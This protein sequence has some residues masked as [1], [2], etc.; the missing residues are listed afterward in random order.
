MIMMHDF[1]KIESPFVRKE[2]NGKYVVT[3]EIAKNYEWVFND[4][5]VHAVEKLHGTCCSV[6]IE[7]GAIKSVWN[8]TERLPFFNKGKRHIIE[9][10][11]ESYERGYLDLPDG[12]WFGELIGKKVNGNPYSLDKHVW[13]PFKTYAWEH[14]SY[15]SWGKYPKDFET[16]SEWFKDLMP[17]Y[18]L[19]IHGKEFNKHFVEGIVFTHPDGR[20]A[21]LRRDMFSWYYENNPNAKQHKETNI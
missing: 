5:S 15:K 1:P 16:I 6:I 10:F 20:Y 7:D 14:L 21:K 9:G 18:S 11:L 8:R 3:P 17:L 19:K 12:L 2:I 4:E 13:S